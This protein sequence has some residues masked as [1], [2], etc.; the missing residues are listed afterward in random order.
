MNDIFEFAKQHKLIVQVEYLPKID[1]YR[2]TLDN[3]RFSVD[4]ML[5]G[6]MMDTRPEFKNTALEHCLHQF[7]LRRM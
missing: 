1:T 6:L 5:D 2:V 3:R 7:K 4:V